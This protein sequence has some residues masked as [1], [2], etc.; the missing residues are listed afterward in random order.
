MFLLIA[1]LMEKLNTLGDS[2]DNMNKI[3]DF[4][5]DFIIYNKIIV[6]VEIFL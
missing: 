1:H 6:F 4:K 2:I 3:S 5:L